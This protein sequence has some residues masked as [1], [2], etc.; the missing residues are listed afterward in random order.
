VNDGTNGARLQHA[1]ALCGI[2][3]YVDAVGYF[4]FGH[5]FTANM[6]GNTVLLGA[7]LVRGDAIA[8]TYAGT[9]AEFALGVMMAVILKRKGIGVY[10]A[11]AANAVVLA[12]L[13][14]VAPS[15]LIVL[16]TLAGA[17]GLQG[18]T[19]SSF[20]GIRL[21][22]VVVTSTLV[23][24]IEGVMLRAS[25][26]TNGPAPPTTQ[27]VQHLAV[28][29]LIYGVGGAGAVAA[30]RMSFPLLVPALVYLWVAWDLRQRARMP[31]DAL[32]RSP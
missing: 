27:H 1:A 14:L 4:Q 28:A 8:L 12:A 25:P 9:L 7:S 15:N 18:G 29:W 16:L 20:S 23:S 26:P 32:A 19:I 31:K 30:E 5:V 11:M 3:G 10:W 2:A 21:P 22:T 6:T 24:L 17:M 13:C